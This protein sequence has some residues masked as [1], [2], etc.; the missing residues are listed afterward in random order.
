MKKIITKTLP[1]MAGYLVLGA[2]FGILL[3]VSGYGLL[4]ALAMSV[5]IYAGSM[6]FVT[7][8]LI[9]GGAS[10]ITAAITTL[11]VNARHLFY[12]ISMVDRYRGAG[13]KKLY[14]MHAL[15]DETYSLVCDDGSGER[16]TFGYYLGVSG[17]NHL[18]WIIGTAIGSLIG[19]AI[20]FDTKGLDFAMTALFVT[21]FIEQ[22]Q[23]TKRHA[24][25]LIGVLTTLVCLLIFGADAFLIPSMVGIVILLTAFKGKIEEVRHE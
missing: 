10:L 9:T 18:Y 11:M 20:T 13:A 19:S 1:V 14:L 21:V 24:P 4:Y 8:S 16:P 15:T 5:F 7:I 2:G 12:G 25:A 3:R 22:W 17:I 6:Q 23:S